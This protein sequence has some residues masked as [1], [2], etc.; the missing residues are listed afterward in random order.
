MTATGLAL[1]ASDRGRCL[2]TWCLAGGDESISPH[3]LGLGASAKPLPIPALTD[4]PVVTEGK[5]SGT[6]LTLAQLRGQ[7]DALITKMT[8]FIS[9]RIT[10]HTS[11]WKGCPEGGLG[12]LSCVFYR[13][14]A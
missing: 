14:L 1:G 3:R 7:N 13:F 6:V 5:G 9:P 8:A 12:E 11:P 10:A 4:G 2:D